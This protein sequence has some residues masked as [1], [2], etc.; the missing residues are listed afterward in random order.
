MRISVFLN[1]ER[2]NEICYPKPVHFDTPTSRAC[3]C[4]SV[5][6][7]VVTTFSVHVAYNVQLTL[8]GPQYKTEALLIR[9][10]LHRIT[11]VVA[12]ISLKQN[13]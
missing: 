3:I 13:G 12:S 7:V 9:E 1:C 2:A 11:H 6:T 5:Y 4:Q 8:I 10:P